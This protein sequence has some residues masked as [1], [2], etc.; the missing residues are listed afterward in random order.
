L[1]VRDDL[2]N[3]PE[4]DVLVTGLPFDGG[5]RHG[6]GARFGPRAVRDASLGAAPFSH[7]LGIDIYDELRVAD[8]GD[9]ALGALDAA[10]ALE[11]IAERSER[12]ARLGIVGG[13]VGGDQTV[14]LAALRGIHYAKLKGV[15][16]VHIDA[17]SDTAQPPAAQRPDQGSAIRLAVEQGLVRPNAVIQIGLRGPFASAS[18]L[19]FALANG[20]EIVTVDEVKWDLH[21][22][23]SQLRKVVRD[24]SFYV[25]VDLTALDPAFAPGVGR[26][27]PGGMN[28]WELQQLLRALVGAEII[29]FDVVELMPALDATGTSALAATTV[30]QEILAALADTRRSARAV[31]DSRRGGRL[32][33]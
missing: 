26:P 10:E 14:T 16:L 23:V 31:P 27:V 30:L 18:E 7:A 2:T 4:V 6:G 12:I 25:S 22:A 8:G 33:P 24:G 13:F 32:S 1:P 15:G 28:T 20:F 29:G 17:S 21:S 9:V 19:D 5:S 11:A 3:L